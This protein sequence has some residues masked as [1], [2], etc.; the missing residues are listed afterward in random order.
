MLVYDLRG[1]MGDIPSYPA[2]DEERRGMRRMRFSRKRC[3]VW[4]QYFGL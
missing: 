2:T 3:G 4:N 1:W